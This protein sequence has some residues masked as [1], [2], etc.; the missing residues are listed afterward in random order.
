M[1][2][3]VRYGLKIKGTIKPVHPEQNLWYREQITFV[4]NWEALK[5]EFYKSVHCE[6][7]RKMRRNI[8][9]Q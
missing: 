7:V 8:S 5:L 1:A 4:L 9:K 2:Q 3:W 6:K